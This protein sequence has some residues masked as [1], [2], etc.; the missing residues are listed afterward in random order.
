MVL[1]DLFGL[2]ICVVIAL[3][4]AALI[5]Q[6]FKYVC[7]LFKRINN[8]LSNKFTNKEIR[9][10]AT[11]WVD[12]SK[13]KCK[14]SIND[15]QASFDLFQIE[16][17]EF[18]NSPE[19]IMNLERAECFDKEIDDLKQGYFRHSSKQKL[20]TNYKGLFNEVSSFKYDKYQVTHF[21]NFRHIF[22]NIDTL[23]KKWNM[24]YVTGE[25]SRSTE[26]FDNIDGKMLDAQQ[27]RA[28]IV[29]ED[30]NLILAGAGSGKTLTIAAKVKY[31]VESKNVDPKDILLITFTKK[32]AAEMQE[33]ISNK[34]KIDVQAYTF[35]KCG[36]DAYKIVLGSRP[37]VFTD[38]PIMVEKYFKGEI[39]KNKQHVKS[40]I[41]FLGLYINIPPNYDDIDSFDQII[42]REKNLDLETIKS[43]V[44]TEKQEWSQSKRTFQGERVK[45]IEEA[46]IAN[47]LYLHGINYEYEKLYPFKTEDKFRKRYRPDFYLTDYDIYLEHF[48]I[49]ENGQVPWLPRIEAQQ[50]IESISWKRDLHKTN[51]TVLL[52]TYSYFN[53][54]GRL[55]IELNKLLKKNGVKYK[56]VDYLEIYKNIIINKNDRTISEFIKLVS[57]FVNLFKS[58]GY[59]EDSFSNLESILDDQNNIFIKNRGKIFLSIVKPF[60]SEYQN[61]LRKKGYIDFNDMIN[62][63]TQNTIEGKIKFNYKYIIVD[64]YQDISVSRF[65]LIKAI[66][67]QNNAVVIAVGDDWQSIYRFAGSDIDLFTNFRK[68]LGHTE[69]LKIESTYRNSQELIDVAS[70]FILKNPKQLNKRLSSSKNQINP[71]SVL[72][73]KQ[74]IC[75]AFIFALEELINHCGDELS[76]LILGRNNYDIEFA[77]DNEEFIFQNKSDV[78][79]IIYK[80]YPN[81]IMEFLT[82]HKSKGLEADHVIVINMEDK[83]TG[84]P[85]KMTDDPILSLVLTDSD[86]SEYA[87]ERRLFYVALTRTRNTIYLLTP[88]NNKSSFIRELVKDNINICYRKATKEEITY[89]NPKCPRCLT[90]TL[91]IREDMDGKRFLGCS[92]YPHCDRSYNNIEIL[93]DQIECEGCHGF[94]VKRN[95]KYGEFYGCTN[96]PMCKNTIE[97]ENL[98][99]FSYLD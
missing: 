51:E 48:G 78:I 1:V 10:N 12:Y 83:L 15:A 49:D 36:L 42:T 4:I 81:M 40:I 59:N 9:D 17:N 47:Y 86:N 20:K 54:Q 27:Q 21:D 61:M 57:T 14:E 34:L 70:K 68:Y 95:G 64:E 26:L 43:K 74:D 44:E 8:F 88:D 85:N 6:G 53:K 80:K 73:Y 84:F 52:E 31:L 45:S 65:K 76:I 22:N 16:R 63:S 25:I 18:I 41:E 93:D 58:N 19:F 7:S 29:D 60:F 99:T 87:E 91:I 11:E 35:H 23:V 67:E 3:W 24:D 69:I 75:E 55:Q 82:V 72:V 94:M 98:D 5:I 66:K 77:K 2:I 92:N 89:N 46:I 38:L 28:V 32:A 79:N 71:I 56:K 96:Y 90:G 30:N 97:I 50:Y 62:F 39:L 13:I 37:D 33:R